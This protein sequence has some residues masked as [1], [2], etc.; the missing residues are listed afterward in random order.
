MHAMA[1]MS[2]NIFFCLNFN[3][4]CMPLLGVVCEGMSYCMLDCMQKDGD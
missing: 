1:K 4:G 3:E 2:C